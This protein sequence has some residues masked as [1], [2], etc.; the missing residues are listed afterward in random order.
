MP[1]QYVNRSISI[2][3]GEHIYSTI[4]DLNVN[5]INSNKECKRMILY[6]EMHDTNKFVLNHRS[7]SLQNDNDIQ[8]DWVEYWKWYITFMFSSLDQFQFLINTFVRFNVSTSSI[9][10]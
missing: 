7:N 1:K 10:I 2:D 6:D 5:H 8:S 9:L 4:A 3:N